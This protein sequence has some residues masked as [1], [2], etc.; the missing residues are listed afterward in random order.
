MRKADVIS[1]FGGIPAAAKKLGITPHAIYQWPDLVP[2][3]SAYTAQVVS[4]GKLKVDPALYPPK[5]KFR[6]SDVENS[7]VKSST[8]VNRLTA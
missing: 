8:P 6:D 3:G 2:K 4:E 7:S 1:F 5:K